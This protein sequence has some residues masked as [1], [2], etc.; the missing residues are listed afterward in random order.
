MFIPQMLAWDES[1]YL[2]NT[3]GETILIYLI[4]CKV[5]K[6]IVMPLHAKITGNS[7]Y[8]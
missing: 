3:F 4:M 7:I 8:E 5:F 6:K 1:F 2:I